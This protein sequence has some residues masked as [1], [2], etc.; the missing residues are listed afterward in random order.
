M[1]V[2]F[3][4]FEVLIAYLYFRGW[5]SVAKYCAKKLPLTTEVMAI[6]NGKVVF[7]RCSKILLE[8]VVLFL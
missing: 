7:S 6:H 1:L 2:F 3:C 5:A 4:F 8:G